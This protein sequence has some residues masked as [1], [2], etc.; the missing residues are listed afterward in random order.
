MPSNHLTT[1]F[2]G[3][4]C[5]WGIT[6]GVNPEMHDRLAAAEHAIRSSFDALPPERRIDPFT[7]EANASFQQWTGV[8]SPI[9]AWISRAAQHSA[10]AAIDIEPA[11]NPYIVTR[12]NGVPGGEPGGEHLRDM[13]NRALAAYDRAMRFV[14][15][16]NA[17]ADVSPR[18]PGE[19][20][21]SVWLRFEATSDA[22]MRYFSV[23]VN[24]DQ[25]TIARIALE[26]ADDVSDEQ[27]LAVIGEDER[28]PLDVALTAVAREQ[29]FRILRDYEHARI[30][31]GRAHV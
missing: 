19:S 3:Q 18:K 16:E 26:N 30:Q 31:I 15:G 10:G 1:T 7:G 21:E 17:A 20:T 8:R 28:I 6:E 5:G 25:A 23:A 29:Y 4:P 14:R 22:L 24:P 13:R 2:L 9:V 11:A 27:L 12:Y